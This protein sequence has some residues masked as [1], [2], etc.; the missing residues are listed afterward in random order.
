MDERLTRCPECGALVAES[1]ACG[2]N[3][4]ALLALEWEV[5]G[6]AGDIA[7]FYAVSSYVLQHPDSLRYTEDSLRGL[8]VA[9]ADVLNAEAT[10]ADLR[11]RAR[12]GAKA[13]GRVTRRE[14][15]DVR[16]WRVVEWTTNVA[17]V[18]VGGVDGY[19][20][21]VRGWAE[22]VLHDLDASGG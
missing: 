22:S 11:L 4:H 19:G 12:R 20:D 18:I 1:G 16:S 10:I 7:H 8:R 6:G 5:P 3:F 15:D 21:R 2:D 17:D 14:G 13:M 9:V